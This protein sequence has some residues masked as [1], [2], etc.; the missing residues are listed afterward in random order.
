MIAAYVLRRILATIPVVFG[1]TLGA[2]VSANPTALY[3]QI[4]ADQIG[5]ASGMFRTWGYI[6]SIA[7]AAIISISFHSGVSDHGLHAIALIMVIV[8][9]L[10]L[11]FTVGDRHLMALPRV[12]QDGRTSQPADEKPNPAP[13]TAQ[14]NTQ[15]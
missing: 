4:P 15:P 10:V 9:V 1:V 12:G 13:A 8:S 2:G 14:N 5:T 6:G 7:S 3:T 11:L